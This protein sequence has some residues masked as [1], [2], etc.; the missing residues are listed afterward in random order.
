VQ[1]P[2]NPYIHP[3]F[4]QSLSRTGVNNK[5]DENKLIP[6]VIQLLEEIK[7]YQ[8][9]SKISKEVIDIHKFRVK[10]YEIERLILENNINEDRIS[11]D[12]NLKA[13]SNV[14]SN[15]SRYNDLL[16]TD[17]ESDQPL[18][19][20]KYV[21]TLK[22]NP[23]GLKTGFPSLD[24][25]VTIQ[26]SNLAFIA[27]RPSHGKTTF[28]L[29][30]L[31]N[32]I[33]ANPGKAFL[34]YSYEE[35]E[36]TIL[37]KIILATIELDGAKVQELCEKYPNK[38]YLEIVE[39][40]VGQYDGTDKMD[41]AIYRAKKAVEEWIN[42]KRLQILDKKPS[43]ESLTSAIIERCMIC[44]NP[45]KEQS[46]EK[47]EVAAVFIDYV[48]KLSTEEERVNRQQEIQR[49]CSVLLNAAQDKRVRAALIL[50]SQANR[51][52]KT[53]D[54]FNL[55]NMKDAG[56]IE[57]TANLVLGVWNPLAAQM[58]MLQ[59]AVDQAEM[60][61]QI[62]DTFCKEKEGGIDLSIL[63]PSSKN[64]NNH[65]NPPTKEELQKAIKMARNKL[66]NLANAEDQTLTI[67]ILKN[68]NGKK[69]LD[70]SLNTRLSQ[71]LI[72]DSSVKNNN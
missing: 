27:A 59:S 7:K 16:T 62:L 8:K 58:Q 28:M 13:I 66:K 40:E 46:I 55:H 72:T 50:G 30:M 29:N 64:F 52:V 19:W 15:I 6:E 12:S 14:L 45:Q 56:N 24:K 71:F 51:D 67:K 3:V 34:F 61:V 22:N 32:M 25:Y 49:I 42:D 68:R 38:S 18:T 26:P 1:V 63:I 53:A 36:K 10:C 43:V 60:T 17:Y 35:E 11:K 37:S 4:I 54:T 2:R 20:G 48:Q 65:Q 21:Q 57:E 9:V 5:N 39:L 41:E 31:K 69:D 47:K 33:E 23:I 44:S 70:I